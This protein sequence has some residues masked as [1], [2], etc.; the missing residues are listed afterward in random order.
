MPQWLDSVKT[1]VSSE[2]LLRYE[3]YVPVISV[4]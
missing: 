4:F 3:P 1:G 2:A